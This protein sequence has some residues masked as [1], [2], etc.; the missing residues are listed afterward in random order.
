MSHPFPTQPILCKIDSRN[1]G[2][3]ATMA[4][5][6][7]VARKFRASVW[8]WSGPSRSYKAKPGNS[9]PGGPSW[10]QSWPFHEILCS[11]APTAPGNSWSVSGCT[12]SFPVVTPGNSWLLPGQAW[13]ALVALSL[14]L[15]S[16]QEI[17]GF[18]GPFQKFLV[19]VRSCYLFCCG[20][21]RIFFLAFMRPSML[22]PFQEILGPCAAKVAL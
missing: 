4:L 12:T 1:C 6:R 13:P 3:A 7:A 10:L 21:S 16:L 19:C 20:H 5:A 17:L 2:F 18:F 22:G 8:A 11:N 9:W 14:L 15:W